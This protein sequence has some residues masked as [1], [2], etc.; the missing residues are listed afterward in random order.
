[1]FQQYGN[2]EKRVQENVKQIWE[3]QSEISRGMESAEFNLRAHQMVL[4]SLAI[5][6]EKLVSHLNDEIFKT[7]HEITVLELS[8]VTL[9]SD[10]G[11][12]PRVVRR[13]DWPYYHEQVEAD[14]RA[15]KEAEARKDAEKKAALE[16][17]NQMKSMSEASAELVKA[18]EE[19]GNDPAE[20][21]AEY[22]SMMA[23]AQRVSVALGHKLR[24]EEYDQ[25]A[26]D[27]AE[28]LIESV[29]LSNNIPTEEMA[30]PPQDDF[31]E[32]ASVFGG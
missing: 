8:D 27:E 16:L 7:E 11:V 12:E 29:E 6:F 19:A 32:G 18:A 4:N 2:L 23:L 26:L 14:L 9:P 25:G 28:R 3:N 21:R 30:Q 31:P 5:E 1:M 15:I 22:A 10:P 17:E 24:G 20:V 13:L